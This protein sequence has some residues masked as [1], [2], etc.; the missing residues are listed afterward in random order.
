[1]TNL[2]LLINNKSTDTAG[3]FTTVSTTATKEQVKAWEL[4]IQILVVMITDMAYLSSYI[5]YCCRS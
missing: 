3:Y 2:T 4:K 5:K 1:M